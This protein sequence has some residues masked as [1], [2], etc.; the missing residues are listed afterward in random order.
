MQRTS[1]EWGLSRCHVENLTPRDTREDLCL[2]IERVEK[3]PFVDE[4]RCPL[5]VWREYRNIF[6]YKRNRKTSF[7]DGG[8]GKGSSSL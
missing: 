8:Y 1:T 2:S 4:G 3:R 5:F 6:S 7:A